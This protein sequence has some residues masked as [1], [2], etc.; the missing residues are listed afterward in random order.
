MQKGYEDWKSKVDNLDRLLELLRQG[1]PA[2]V[3]SL[4]HDWET[5][6]VKA[7][8]IERYWEPTPFPFE[9]T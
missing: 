9:L 1:T 6:A 4:L 5:L 3:A 8:R 7:R 2:P